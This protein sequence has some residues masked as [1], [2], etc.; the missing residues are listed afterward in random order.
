M[1][2]V[3]SISIPLHVVSVVS[4]CHHKL[5]QWH[6]CIPVS[7]VKHSTIITKHSREHLPSQGS[8]IP[9]QGSHS[10][11]PRAAIPSRWLKQAQVTSQGGISRGRDQQRLC[12]HMKLLCLLFQETMSALREEQAVQCQ[13]AAQCHMLEGMNGMNGVLGNLHQPIR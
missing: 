9:S 4:G 5:W 12:T 3:L 10:L 11:R 6:T 7:P 8:H 13:L 1:S 2:E